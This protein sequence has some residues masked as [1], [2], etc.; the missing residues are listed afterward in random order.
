MESR[1]MTRRQVEQKLGVSRS[2]VYRLLEAGAFPKPIKI[3]ERAIR[4]HESEIDEYVAS[5]SRAGE[6]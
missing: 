3:A 5:R 6:G 2:T 4:W 1:L